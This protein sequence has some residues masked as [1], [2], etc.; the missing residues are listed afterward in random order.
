MDAQWKN[1]DKLELAG[2]C[3]PFASV[4]GIAPCFC[5]AEALV[6]GPEMN[7]SLVFPVPV[8]SKEQMEA[9]AKASMEALNAAI[10]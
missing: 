6:P 5:L 3:G 1:V 9:L 7:I 2:T 8:Y 10:R 4:H